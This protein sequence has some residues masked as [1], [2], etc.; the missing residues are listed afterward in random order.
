MIYP[1]QFVTVNNF[2]GKTAMIIDNVTDDE[3]KQLEK[4]MNDIY[5]RKKLK[6]KIKYNKEK[7]NEV[8]Q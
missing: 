7:Q 8:L 5:F 1:K 2:D 3:K 4:T 6:Y